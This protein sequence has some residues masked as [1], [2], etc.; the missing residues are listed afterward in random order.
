ML[1]PMQVLFWWLCWAWLINGKVAIKGDKKVTWKEKKQ[2]GKSMITTALS[3]L[4]VLCWW[5]STRMRRWTS[6]TMTSSGRTAGRTWAP[7]TLTSTPWPRRHTNACPGVWV[8]VTYYL[9][10]PPEHGLGINRGIIPKSLNNCVIERKQYV[11]CAS[12]E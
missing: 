7:W 12:F 6:T 5:P 1:S 10:K 11:P 3:P 2:Y 9:L 8:I 4:Q